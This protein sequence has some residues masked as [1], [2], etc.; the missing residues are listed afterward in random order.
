MLVKY[1]NR[2]G[3]PMNCN[4]EWTIQWQRHHSAPDAEQ[5]RQN[6]IQKT[7]KMRNTG[8]AKNRGSYKRPVNIPIV[9][10]GKGAVVVVIIWL[11]YLQLPMPSV[12]ITADVVGSTSGQGEVH[13]TM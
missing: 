2:L 1:N 6:T 13:N 7:N 8:P 3:K 11:L 9:N 10:P 5:R 12:P 4:Q